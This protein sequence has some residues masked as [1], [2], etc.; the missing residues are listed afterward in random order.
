MFE[1]KLILGCYPFQD[2]DPFVLEE[3]PHIFFAGNQPEYSSKLV[4]GSHLTDTD[5][6]LGDDGQKVRI[7]SIPKFSETGEIVL[8]NTSTLESEVIK[9]SAGTLKE[10]GI[11]EEPTETTDIVMD[12][13][14]EL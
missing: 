11:K 3:T 9:F 13:I 7:I 6:T 2:R 8:V 14:E 5:L 10:E 1:S 4:H 12:D